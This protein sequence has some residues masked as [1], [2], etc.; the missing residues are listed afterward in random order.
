MQNVRGYIY[1]E[2]KTLADIKYAFG[3]FRFDQSHFSF[4]SS[5][6]KDDKSVNHPGVFITGQINEK[7]TSKNVITLFRK[8]L[9]LPQE[10]K[11]CD[12][13]I[14]SED[15]IEIFKAGN[16]FGA[17]L[18]IRIKPPV[19]KENVDLFANQTGE[20]LNAN[21]ISLREVEGDEK[22]LKLISVDIISDQDYSKEKTNIEDLAKKLNLEIN[23]YISINLYKS[24]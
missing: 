2:K 4:F 17:Y 16:N 5:L 8:L 7:Y 24:I 21:D 20:A 6:V 14:E 13:S 11:H 23:N 9:N 12:L 1:F 18:G 3:N 15:R 10:V 19:T 22:G